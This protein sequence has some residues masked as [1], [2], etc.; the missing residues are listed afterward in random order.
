MHTHICPGCGFTTTICECQRE[1]SL[2]LTC[3]D[4]CAEL[5]WKLSR[6]RRPSPEPKSSVFKNFWFDFGLVVVVIAF[7]AALYAGFKGGPQ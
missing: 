1:E 6:D 3:S 4:D 2:Y 7:L 5:A